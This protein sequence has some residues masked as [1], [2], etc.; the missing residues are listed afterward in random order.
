MGENIIFKAITS[1]YHWNFFKTIEL[2]VLCWFGQAHIIL[3]YPTTKYKAPTSIFSMERWRDLL[4]RQYV[5]R[6]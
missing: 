2:Y 3:L 1:L 5:Q 6:T 4:G